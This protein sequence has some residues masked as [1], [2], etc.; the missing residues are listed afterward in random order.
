MVIQDL[1]G[2]LDSRNRSVQ[3][4][5]LK[6]KELEGTLSATNEKRYKLQDTIG[7][8]EKELQ[9]TKAHINQMADMQTR[10]ATAG[11][12]TNDKF[13]KLLNELDR[14]RRL[15]FEGDMPERLCDNTSYLEKKS[16]QQQ[17]IS[18]NRSR[19]S[20]TD[21]LRKSYEDN[22][23]KIKRTVS[24]CGTKLNTKLN[25]TKANN[26]NLPQT[27]GVCYQTQQYVPNINSTYNPS[28]ATHTSQIDNNESD[29][30]SILNKNQTYFGCDETYQPILMKGV[31][32]YHVMN[33]GALM[34]CKPNVDMLCNNSL[35]TQDIIAQSCKQIRRNIDESLKIIENHQRKS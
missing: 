20:S 8:M 10:Y 35:I 31:K 15:I 29:L 30:T 2:S 7:T 4:L 13:D 6:I 14:R 27:Y 25:K 23:T 22:T 18:F 17:S 19:R 12:P 16:T 21:L 33:E 34:W 32:E 9:S 28:V 3:K 24:S 5:E 11:M 1:Q 26:Y